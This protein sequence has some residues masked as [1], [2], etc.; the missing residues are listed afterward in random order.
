MFSTSLKQILPAKLNE[1]TC[2]S[3]SATGEE[4]E[5]ADEKEEKES[6][7]DIQM[8]VDDQEYEEFLK[9]EFN[10]NA[11][12]KKVDG[13]KSNPFKNGK[14]ADS[15]DG[16]ASKLSQKEQQNLINE[17]AFPRASSENLD[18][19]EQAPVQDEKGWQ[20][21]WHQTQLEIQELEMR[22]NAIKAMMEKSKGKDDQ[23]AGSQ[24]LD[25]IESDDEFVSDGEYK[26]ESELS[27]SREDEPRRSRS[28]SHKSER[29]DRRKRSKSRED[30]RESRREKTEKREGRRSRSRSK[31]SRNNLERAGQERRERRSTSKERRSSKEKRLANDRKT[32]PIDEEKQIREAVEDEY[33]DIKV[34]QKRAEKKSKKSMKPDVSRLSMESGEIVD[35][36]SDEEVI[37]K[38]KSRKAR[39]PSVTSSIDSFGRNRRRKR[40]SYSPTRR[41]SRG[42]ESGSL[43]SLDEILREAELEE[44]HSGS[45]LRSQ[46]GLGT[47][48]RSHHHSHHHKSH[49]HKS[50][51]QRSYVDLDDP[52]A[53]HEKASE[54]GEL[55]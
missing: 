9:S 33:L 35:D 12:N 26:N 19:C 28:E 18:N 29:E 40:R 31:N 46:I 3:L 24:L 37:E 6:P 51:K 53:K 39:S 41:E 23:K 8:N 20:N 4:H 5:S 17:L 36:E 27:N 22:A 43:S 48:S 52:E 11:V 42:R 13:S 50:K 1:L 44:Q 15:S 7:D 49:H 32:E 30:T 55:A 38:K 2:F 16:G 25:N 10:S 14:P 54:E 45:R 34:D 47:A 21:L